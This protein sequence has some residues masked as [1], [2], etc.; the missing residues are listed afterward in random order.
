MKTFSSP[1]FSTLSVNFQSLQ[2]DVFFTF[3]EIHYYFLVNLA[4]SIILLYLKVHHPCLHTNTSV[5]TE[6]IRRN[7]H[8]D[9]VHIGNFTHPLESL[10]RFQQFSPR[11]PSP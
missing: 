7:S 6:L 2:L 10:R 4:I 5:Y 11:F 3:N 8:A 9:S 1:N